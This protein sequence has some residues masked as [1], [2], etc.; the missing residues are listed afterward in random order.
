MMH[1]P[2]NIRFTTWTC[3]KIIKMITYMQL[4]LSNQRNSLAMS[5]TIFSG[6]IFEQDALPAF[7]Q[8]A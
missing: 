6:T 8:R 3:L 7:R 2:I 4:K 5:G 1:G